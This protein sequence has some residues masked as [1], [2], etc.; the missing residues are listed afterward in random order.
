MIKI[1]R[2]VIVILVISSSCLKGQSIKPGF[3]DEVNSDNFESVYLIATTALT[4]INA[5]TTY[6][7]IAKL[8]K[9]N[10][11]R[12]NGIF[13]IIS[14]GAQIALGVV[15]INTDKKNAFIPTSINIGV[16]MTTLVTSII[17][18]SIKNPPK[19][20]HISLNLIYIPHHENQ[21]SMVGLTCKMQFK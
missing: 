7:T 21:V 4:A 6:F 9:Y 5:T 13:G 12:S 19:N 20:D 16:G 18:L 2:L 10:S 1:L 3:G 11:H 15:N 8:H 14:G 17:R